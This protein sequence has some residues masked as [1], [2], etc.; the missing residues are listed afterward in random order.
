[1]KKITVIL[2]CIAVLLIPSA[3]GAA[4]IVYR[5][6]TYSVDMPSID[7]TFYISAQY[8]KGADKAEEIEMNGGK[9]VS[10]RELAEKNNKYVK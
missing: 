7:D 1:M 3:A 8:N 5:G 6:K 10:L 2:M 9:Y 4:E